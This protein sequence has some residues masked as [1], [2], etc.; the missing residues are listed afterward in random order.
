MSEPGLL[1]QISIIYTLC[2]S[3]RCASENVQRLLVGN[4]CDLT[5]KRVVT[6]EQ[7]KEYA[8]SLGIEVIETSAKNATN[9]EKAF[10]TMAT[11]IRNSMKNS[12][13][14]CKE[15][16]K[17]NKSPITK[18]IKENGDIITEKIKT[19]NVLIGVTGSVAAVKVLRY[20]YYLYR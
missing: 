11:Q 2:K 8:D 18:E 7:A 3:H 6:Y 13:G 14:K 16:V 5:A 20:Y 12:R 10:L 17:D 9:V 15:V 4:K 1:M 19:K